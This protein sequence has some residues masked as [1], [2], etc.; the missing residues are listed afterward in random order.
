MSSSTEA[1]VKQNDQGSSDK[2]IEY[3]LAVIDAG[4][5]ISDDDI[6]VTRFRSLLNQLTDTYDPTPTQFGDQTVAAQKM[7]KKSER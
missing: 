5:Y 7:L 4:G 6:R 3:Q 2:P 1:Q